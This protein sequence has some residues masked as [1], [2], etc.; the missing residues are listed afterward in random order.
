MT[1][2]IQSSVTFMAPDFTGPETG[3][4]FT[5]IEAVVQVEGDISE[6]VRVVEGLQR[7]LLQSTQ[8]GMALMRLTSS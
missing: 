5:E 2:Q 3:I 7:P 8:A 6:A 4:E 1:E